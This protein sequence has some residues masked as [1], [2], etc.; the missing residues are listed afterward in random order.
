MKRTNKILMVCLMGTL[1]FSCQKD[2]LV[3]SDKSGVDN[4]QNLTIKNGGNNIPYQDIALVNGI[5]K[6]NDM[7]ALNETLEELEYLYNYDDSV[8]RASH[9]N[10]TDDSLMVLIY[11]GIVI[12]NE[13]AAFENFE[14]TM[15][16]TSLR[17]IINSSETAWRNDTLNENAPYDDN[18]GHIFVLETSIRSILNEFYEVRVGD[19]IF[20]LFDGGYIAIPAADNPELELIRRDIYSANTL[21]N[22]RIEGDLFGSRT[23]CSTNKWNSGSINHPTLPQYRMVWYLALCKYPWKKYAIAKVEGCRKYRFRWRINRSSV[24]AKVY[25]DVNCNNPSNINPNGEFE[26]NLNKYKINHKKY[27]WRKTKSCW[28][29]G[30]H[31]ANGIEYFSC[32]VF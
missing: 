8:F 27:T 21:S 23:S 13:F 25:G 26:D 16:F 10:L 5:L 22:A 19:T 31:K 2:N 24:L 11:D 7:T 4:L 29:K 14:A 1:L 12:Q 9:N 17:S 18:P 3:L 28:I 32:L 15:G 6:F 30:Q 20:T